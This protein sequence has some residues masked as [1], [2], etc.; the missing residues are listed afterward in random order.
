MGVAKELKCRK[1]GNVW[2]HYMGVGF[3]MEPVSG[4]KERNF[5][6]EADETIKCPVCN[7]TDFEDAPVGEIFLWD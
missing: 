5:T 4:S 7:S 2:T 1:C 3:N 6:G